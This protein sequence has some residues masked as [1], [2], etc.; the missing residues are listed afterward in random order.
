MSS[1]KH[2]TALNAKRTSSEQPSQKQEQEQSQQQIP[3]LQLD[4]RHIRPSAGEY[5]HSHRFGQAP[6]HSTADPSPAMTIDDDSFSS[7]RPH[8]MGHPGARIYPV[9][10]DT[11]GDSTGAPTTTSNCTA[12]FEDNAS[13]QPRVV[14]NAQLNSDL[15]KYRQW[16]AATGTL[17]VT[18]DSA[19]H[20]QLLL[21]NLPDPRLSQSRVGRLAVVRPSN[22]NVIV[23]GARDAAGPS[24]P[25]VEAIYHVIEGASRERRTRSKKR[26]VHKVVRGYATLASGSTAHT[27]DTA[28][29]PPTRRAQSTPDTPLHQATLYQRSTQMPSLMQAVDQRQ[30]QQPQQRQLNTSRDGAQPSKHGISQIHVLPAARQNTDVSARPI[31][32]PKSRLG[33]LQP[34][35]RQMPRSAEVV[36]EGPVYRRNGSLAVRRP[37]SIMVFAD[38]PKSEASASNPE[39]EAQEEISDSYYDDIGYDLVNTEIDSLYCRSFDIDEL[40]DAPERRT[41]CYNIRKKNLPRRSPSPVKAQSP[42][43]SLHSDSNTSSAKKRRSLRHNAESPT[44][45]I[46]V[47][48]L[49]SPDNDS[50]KLQGVTELLSGIPSPAI[51]QTKVHGPDIVS[52][53]PI[54]SP[55]PDITTDVSVPISDIKKMSVDD[56]NTSDMTKPITSEEDIEFYIRMLSLRSGIPAEELTPPVSPPSQA[57]P[58]KQ[59]QSPS[60]VKVLSQL[61]S[62]QRLAGKQQRR[63][64]QSS[65]MRPTIHR[66]QQDSIYMGNFWPNGTTTFQSETDNIGSGVKCHETQASCY[67]LL[68]RVSLSSRLFSGSK[69]KD[70]L[71]EANSRGIPETQYNEKHPYNAANT[72]N[73][74][75]GT[76]RTRGSSAPAEYTLQSGADKLY[77]NIEREHMAKRNHSLNSKNNGQSTKIEYV[78]RGVKMNS[79]DA[80]SQLRKRHSSAFTAATVD[81]SSD[82]HQNPAEYTAPVSGHAEPDST[83]RVSTRAIHSE[84]QRGSLTTRSIAG[85]GSRA[86]PLRSIFPSP[87]WPS[88]LHWP[89]SATEDASTT[90]IYS[91]YGV[92]A[93]RPP[94]LSHIISGSWAHIFRSQQ[95][96][97]AVNRPK[98]RRRRRERVG[99]ACAYPF[100]L[101][102]NCLLWWLGPCIG[103]ARECRAMFSTR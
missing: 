39:S 44:D 81:R 36:A 1:I 83:S 4:K 13:V 23:V 2:R 9:E 7:M 57:S 85:K 5:N 93:Q 71:G 46:F 27:Q 84:F 88:R 6:L 22:T 55:M 33:K 54:A 38:K 82:R 31:A 15:Q 62:E 101:T 48:A 102:Y 98:P 52:S 41:S 17:G 89:R 26:P 37:E 29:P 96:G 86:R 97:L 35:N 66:Y 63:R 32:I 90:S 95:A 77:R 40:P 10:Q 78:P 12:R 76:G 43:D 58:Y 45:D 103:L 79:S 51:A 30:R 47:D 19:L 50:F 64:S 25:S 75:A 65:P 94:Y 91:M 56:A 80:S 3:P 49:E 34:T 92:E 72:A 68:S 59:Q 67:S 53:I 74:T 28:A 69:T 20:N 14:S 70:T 99:D 21:V 60:S 8:I 87:R 24:S 16:R 11:V 42:V 61:A 100:H 73:L 18:R